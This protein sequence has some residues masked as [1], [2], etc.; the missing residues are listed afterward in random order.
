MSSLTQRLTLGGEEFVVEAK[1]ANAAR[2]WFSVEP[3]R[4]INQAYD[5]WSAVYVEREAFAKHPRINVDIDI[6]ARFRR[7]LH[8]LLD[9]E[10]ERGG[11][12][13]DETW[14]DDDEWIARLMNPFLRDLVGEWLIVYLKFGESDDDVNDAVCSISM[15]KEG[16]ED[17]W[18][19]GTRLAEKVAA[20]VIKMA[21]KI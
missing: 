4:R 9:D 8:A 15:F 3:A 21:E 7:E 14:D 11:G 2:W 20:Y 1:S 16:C 17:L 13:D 19:V 12:V 18:E 6:F 5:V 10:D